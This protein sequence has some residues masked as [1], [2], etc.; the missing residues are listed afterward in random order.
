MYVLLLDR[1][2]N[3]RLNVNSYCTGDALEASRGSNMKFAFV[4]V[5]RCRSGSGSMMEGSASP[6]KSIK[7]YGRSVWIVV[8][9]SSALARTPVCQAT[10]CPRRSSEY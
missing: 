4:C 9:H 5:V 2:G 8:F 6:V 7:G 1:R 10:W 3:G